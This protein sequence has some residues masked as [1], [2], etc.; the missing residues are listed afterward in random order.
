MTPWEQ[1]V[2]MKECVA[3]IKHLRTH[4]AHLTPKAEAYDMLQKIMHHIPGK[5]QGYSEDIVYKLENEIESI[6]K[7][8]EE[9]QE[10]AT[11]PREPPPDDYGAHA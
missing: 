10:V 9:Q 2:M 6:V 11:P 1:V 5:S 4:I 8:R 7:L 3:E